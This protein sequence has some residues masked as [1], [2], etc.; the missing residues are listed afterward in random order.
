[1]SSQFATMMPYVIPLESPTCGYKYADIFTTLRHKIVLY[2]TACHGYYIPPETLG[3][4]QYLFK[5]VDGQHAFQAYQQVSQ[6]LRR[7]NMPKQNYEPRVPLKFNPLSMKTGQ[8][9]YQTSANINYLPQMQSSRMAGPYNTHG[10]SVSV[11]PEQQ[12]E[13]S[14]LPLNEIEIKDGITL[15]KKKCFYYLIATVNDTTTQPGG[16]NFL[17]PI[18]TGDTESWLF[19]KGYD[20]ITRVV[21]NTVQG[22][23]IQESPETVPMT[24]QL[25]ASLGQKFRLPYEVNHPDM[26]SWAT[27]KHLLKYGS[28]SYVVVQNG[29]INSGIDVTFHGWDW[30][31]QKKSEDGFKIED[32][33]DFVVAANQNILEDG[34]DG[35]I[36]LGPK[37]LYLRDRD[38]SRKNF[39]TSLDAGWRHVRDASVFIIRL[40]HPEILDKKLWT[41]K[42]LISFGPEFP[43]KA[44]ANPDAHF[45]PPIPTTIRDGAPRRPES[46]R[47]KLLRIG[48]HDYQLNDEY[49][50]I[51]MN[52]TATSSSTSGEG[53][54]ILMDT[55][56]PL[57]VF[58]GHVVSQML[59]DEK[60]VGPTGSGADTRA[61][62]MS[63][64]AYSNLSNKDMCFEFQGENQQRIPVYVHA[65]LFLSWYPVQPENS[66]NVARRHYFPIKGSKT[67]R[68]ALGQNWYWAAIVKHCIPTEKYLPPFVQVMPSAHFYDKDAGRDILPEDMLLKSRHPRIG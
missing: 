24:K 63:D 55:G 41:L 50:W 35:N 3:S 12:D 14:L 34:Y 32:G 1:M 31:N 67:G 53:I 56:A 4:D 44:P 5:F 59:S 30:I 19:K 21:A 11:T 47:V 8:Q 62:T 26:H 46:W 57:S 18:D 68:Y 7:N 43:L 20:F 65:R 38:S 51:Y 60:W 48:I 36:G 15:E 52:D 40:V 64:Q 16:R 10:Y 2:D 9:L 45:S 28:S 61:P 42:L 17:L 39:L 13:N 33:F 49:T 66:N 37:L 23:K 6:T 27:P 54:T 29:P 22:D 58:P 25:L